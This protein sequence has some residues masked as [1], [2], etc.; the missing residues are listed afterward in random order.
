MTVDR[1]MTTETKPRVNTVPIGRYERA[2]CEGCGIALAPPKAWVLDPED[3]SLLMFHSIPCR[4]RYMR[5]H[6]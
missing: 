1:A 4:S 3:G 5:T 2:R 6:R